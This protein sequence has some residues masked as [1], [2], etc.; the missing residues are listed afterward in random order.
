MSASLASDLRRD[1]EPRSAVHARPHLELVPPPAPSE[2]YALDE[3]ELRAMLPSL[4]RRALAW[5]SALSSN[6]C[7]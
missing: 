5:N 3:P 2:R 7:K 4:R 1:F 6:R